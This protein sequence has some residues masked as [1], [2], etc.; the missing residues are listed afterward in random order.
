[1]L[2]TTGIIALSRKVNDDRA[3]KKEAKQGR[4]KIGNSDV[5]RQA[6]QSQISHSSSEDPVESTHVIGIQ[7]AASEIKYDDPSDVV[8][9]PTNESPTIYSP[10][11]TIHETAHSSSSDIKVTSPVESQRAVLSSPIE[12]MSTRNTPHLEANTSDP[13]PLYSE[14]RLSTC[15]SPTSIYSSDMGS[16]STKSADTRSILT[17]SSDS[18]TSNAI[19]VKTKGSDL[20]SGFPY[21]PALFDCNVHP[22]KWDAFT[23][24]VIDTT[25]FSGRDRAQIWAAS[26]ATAMTGAIGTSIWLGRYGDDTMRSCCA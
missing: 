13:P 25:K 12:T 3:R 5:A 20:N 9:S 15:Y 26:A 7:P 2:L 1:M 10:I 19:R 14:G 4:L 8:A 6:F 17:V 18:S 22:E 24:Q 11:P 21:H 16:K 23:T